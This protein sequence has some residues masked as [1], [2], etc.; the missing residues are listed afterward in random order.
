MNLIITWSI[1][2]IITNQKPIV[3]V[4]FNQKTLKMK[5]PKF[6]KRFSVN[7]VPAFGILIAVDDDS[8]IFLFGFINV[9]FNFENLFPEEENKF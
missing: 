8:I 6:L 5:K 4:G 7:V 1:I 3:M 9:S 2:Q